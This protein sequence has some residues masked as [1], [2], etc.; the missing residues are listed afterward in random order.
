MLGRL[1]ALLFLVITT[2]YLGSSPVQAQDL[3]DDA[4]AIAN[5]IGEG[6]FA[7][8]DW[9]LL[10]ELLLEPT[11]KKRCLCTCSVWTVTRGPERNGRPGRIISETLDTIGLS[12]EEV[13]KTAKC[14]DLD[15]KDES[16]TANKCSGYDKLGNPK[17]GNHK[18][19][20][21]ARP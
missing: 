14:S 3:P 4:Y 20:V 19:C 17:N 7:E 1:I 5:A 6:A 9:E 2:T 15:D 21:D 18:E 13:D 10:E 11:T 12:F 16:L 8:D